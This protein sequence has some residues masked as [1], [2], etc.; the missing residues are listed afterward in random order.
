MPGYVWITLGWYRDQW[1]TETV[2]QDEIEGCSDSV[3]ESLL[4][5]SI[6]I[7]EANSAADVNA[8]TDVNLV[9]I[10]VEMCLIFCNKAK[11]AWLYYVISY[12]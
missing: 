4:Y 2:S 8:R 9:N 7:Q 5:Q 10:I 3:I 12:C 11:Q 6:A 1:W